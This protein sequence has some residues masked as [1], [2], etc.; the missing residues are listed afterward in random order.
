MGTK[1]KLQR[2]NVC[3][4]AKI[5]NAKVKQD[6]YKPRCDVGPECFVTI[7]WAISVKCYL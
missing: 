7:K 5:E 6:M 3:E 1:I 4:L 2:V